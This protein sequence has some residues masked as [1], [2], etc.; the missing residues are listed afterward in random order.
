M[1]CVKIFKNC[2]EKKMYFFLLFSEK[3]GFDISC[4]YQCLKL[5][6]VKILKDS[7]G[8]EGY[9]DKCYKYFF[10]FPWKWIL[11]YLSEA[12]HFNEY[13]TIYDVFVEKYHTYPNRRLPHL[14]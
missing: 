2:S 10:P 11:Y 13:P 9:S 6:Y 12:I 1:N 3:V 14:P 5:K 8:K 4:T 7:I